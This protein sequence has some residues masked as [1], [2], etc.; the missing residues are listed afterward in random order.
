M[1][2]SYDELRFNDVT[3]M[4]KLEIFPLDDNDDG[5]E[6]KSSLSLGKNFSHPHNNGNENRTKSFPTN[7]KNHFIN[8]ILFK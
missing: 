7:K 2:E 4:W 6:K 5:D 1:N 8:F 3:K